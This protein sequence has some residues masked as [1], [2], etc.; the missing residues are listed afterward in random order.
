MGGLQDDVPGDSS[1]RHGRLAPA[2]L[3]QRTPS[4]EMRS[5]QFTWGPLDTVQ[6]KLVSRD[7]QGVQSLFAGLRMPD[8]RCRPWAFGQG[9]QFE[10]WGGPVAVGVGPL[11]TA[12]A[13]FGCGF[14]SLLC[15]QL[16]VIIRTRRRSY[17]RKA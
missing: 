4:S 5:V 8:W 17:P 10:Y 2:V 9:S 13:D 16:N 6:A 14:G 12:G 3:K 11:F 1:A 15:S 7:G